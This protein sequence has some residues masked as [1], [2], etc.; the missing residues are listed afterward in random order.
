VSKIQKQ[1]YIETFFLDSIV[2]TLESQKLQNLNLYKGNTDSSHQSIIICTSTSSTQMNGVVKKLN[3]LIFD[4]S[5]LILEGRNSSWMLIEVK[6]ILIHIFT[7]ES[8]DFYMLEDLYFDCE[9]I[10]QHG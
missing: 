5:N 9:L 4:K 1:E 7:K 6:D 3:E 2:D 8:R 10:Y